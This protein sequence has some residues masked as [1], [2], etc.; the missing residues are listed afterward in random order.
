MSKRLTKEEILSRFNKVHEGKG[1]DYSLF[2]SDDFKYERIVQIIQVICPKHGLFTQSIEHHLRGQGCQKCAEE[3]RKEKKIKPFNVFLEEAVVVNGRKYI[4]LEDTYKKCSE[5]MEMICTVCGT[6]FKQKPTKHLIGE[7]CPNCYKNSPP[8]NKMSLETFEEMATEVHNG[9]Y[10]YIH[11]FTTTKNDVTIVCP[12]HG[13]FRQEAQ[14]HL[15]GHG[16]PKCNRS[17]LETEMSL[18]LERNGIEFEEQKKFDWLEKMALDFYIP[19]LNIAIE[20]QGSQHFIPVE[21]FGGEDEFKE[22]IRRDKK[23]L[24]LCEE[25]GIKVI[26]YSSN[27]VKNQIGGEFPYDVILSEGKLKECLGK[28]I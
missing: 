18:F 26:Y 24:S 1:Y 23:K 22:I 11:D 21:R 4:Y 17:K 15:Q 7:G 3:I 20:C 10:G 27:K 5:D 14:S 16:C 12:I 2:L 28:V 25:H 6:K 13:E 9:R 8:N 19:K